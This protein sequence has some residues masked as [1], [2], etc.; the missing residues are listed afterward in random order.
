MATLYDFLLAKKGKA[1][2]EE[3]IIAKSRLSVYPDIRKQPDQIAGNSRI[4]GDISPE[5]QARVIDL[6]LEIGARYKL[7]YREIAYLLLMIKVESGFNPDAAAGTTTAAGLAQYTVATIAEIK[8][9]IYA[10]HYLGFDLDLSGENIFV[11][12][13]GV[14]AALLSYFVCRKRASEDFPNDIENNIYLYHHEGWYFK[15]AEKEHTKAVKEVRE[16]ISKKIMGKLDDLERLLKDQS[17]F[18]FTL[19]TADGHP[20]S[21]QPFAIVLPKNVDNDKPAAVQYS[22]DVEVV[23]GKTDDKGQTPI[24]PV[25]ALSE[26]VFAIINSEYNKL[27]QSFPGRGAGKLTSYKIKKGDTLAQIAKANNTTVEAIAKE[28]N[29]ENPSKVSIGQVLRIPLG[30]GESQP[31]YWWR[32]PPIEWLASVIGEKIQA[33]GVEDSAAVIEHKRSYVALPMGNKAHDD[34]VD[35]NNVRISGQKKLDEVSA[36][37]KS[38]AVPHKTNEDGGSKPVT[39]GG[40]TESS[41]KVIPGLL[42]PLEKKATADYHEGARRFGASRSGRRHAGIDLYADAGTVVRSMADGLVL[43][44]SKFYCETWVVEVDHGTFIARYGEIDKNRNNIFVE[45]GDKIRRGDKIGV[46]GK[47]VGIKVSSNMLHL[48]MY[49]TIDR[50]PLTVRDNMPFQRRKDLIDPTESIDQAVFS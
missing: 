43:R 13:R 19:K 18:Q 50:S 32:R 21:N 49:S 34:K 16:I 26:V 12:E 7:S 36:N 30:G 8:K 35:H 14:Y 41:K 29:I 31:S 23:F 44:V 33:E 45:A 25:S 10:K 42:Y 2:K 47:L 28:N 11:A 37:K 17:K 4:Y 15:P 46:V 40:G 24:V 20:Y 22:S 38:K 39:K 1:Y 9:P 27:I 6:V 48:E 5:N 3:S